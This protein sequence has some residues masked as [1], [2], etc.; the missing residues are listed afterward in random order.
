MVGT[1]GETGLL[2]EP[3]NPEAL[4][5]AI[6]SLLDDA[7]T[8]RAT[9]RGRSPARHGALHLAGHG[10]WHGGL[11]RRDSARSPTARLNDL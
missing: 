7:E 3:N 11:L 6:R 10:S 9:R 4:V 2:V 8:A 1:S 5:D